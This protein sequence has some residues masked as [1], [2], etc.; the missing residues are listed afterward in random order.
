MAIPK[1][2]QLQ[3]DPAE[4]ERC[5]KD[6]VYFYNFYIRKEGEPV[7]DAEQFKKRTEL[8]MRQQTLLS[9]IEKSNPLTPDDANLTA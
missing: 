2:Q 6:P 7:L 9:Q 1:L 3:K 4:L 5:K 8:L